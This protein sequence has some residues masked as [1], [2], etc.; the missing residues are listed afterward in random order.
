MNNEYMNQ[1]VDRPHY[2]YYV[3]ID[4]TKENFETSENN[5]IVYIMLGVIATACVAFLYWL[6]KQ[7]KAQQNKRYTSISYV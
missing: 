2:G 1:F 6:R 4:I 3:D 5:A 7:E